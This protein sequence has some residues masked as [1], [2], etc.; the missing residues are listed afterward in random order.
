[1]IRISLIV[2]SCIKNNINDKFVNTSKAKNKLMLKIKLKIN[3]D[4]KNYN[5]FVPSLISNPANLFE[6]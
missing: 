1:M 4:F 3:A 6:A 5:G 2:N